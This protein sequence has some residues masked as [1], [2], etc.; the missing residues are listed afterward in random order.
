MKQS[1]LEIKADPYFKNFIKNRRLSKSTVSVYTGRLRSFC[2]FLDKNPMELVKDTQKNPGLIEENLEN[3]IENLK[4]EGKSSR[5]II[6][7]LDTVK[8]FYNEFDIDT[9]GIK[10][11]ISPEID[12]L[13]PKKIISINEINEALELS[14]LRDKAII[15]M[16]LS[17]G[18]EATEIR[19][20]TYGNFINSIEE[21][22][23]LNHADKFNIN[24]I[25]DKLF[26]EDQIVGTWKIEKHRTGKIYVTFNNPEST[27]TILSYLIDRE[28][29]NKTIK[30]LKDPLF[31]NSKNQ[32]LNKSAY[33]SIFKRV[34]DRAN[35]GYITKRRRFFS[36]TMLR[37]YFKSRLHDSG[38]DNRTIGAFLG[39]NLDYSVDYPTEDEIRILKDRY[40][41]V[42]GSLSTTSEEKQKLKKVDSDEYYNLMKKLD[43]KDKELN[44]I[45]KHLEQIKQV[46]KNQPN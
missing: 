18:M 21:Y 22:V 8:A 28:R 24:K 43:E 2:E 46:I 29:N 39:Q 17:S 25:A 45:K 34:N 10:R 35:F 30:S 7:S 3:F 15:L 27:K 19:N 14:N 26:K 16:H 20:L 40:I 23:D 12:Q 13:T 32:A 11:I 31:V 5:T 37:K 38:L 4:L 1:N 6:N 33:G 44:E 41:D 9:E 42:L 36:S